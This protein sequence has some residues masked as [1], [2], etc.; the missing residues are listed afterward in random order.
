MS[1]LFFFKTPIFS[2]FLLEL[3]KLILVQKVATVLV[4]CYDFHSD[5]L[6]FYFV[7]SYLGA[8]AHFLR[9]ALLLVPLLLICLSRGEQTFINSYISISG[10]NEF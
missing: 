1:L 7:E 10:S 3:R 6:E 9:Q 5:Q 4:V 8:V 2:Q